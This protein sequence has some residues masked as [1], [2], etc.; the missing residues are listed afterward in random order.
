MIITILLILLGIALIVVFA[1]RKKD[2]DKA[3]L[4]IM[5]ITLAA[6]VLAISS[7]FFR[8]GTTGGYDPTLD[9]ALAEVAGN[10]I[11]QHAQGRRT[12]FIAEVQQASLFDQT[13]LE[14]MRASFERNQM[15]ILAVEPARPGFVP[16]E[17]V[18]FITEAGLGIDAIENALRNH[19]D[20]EVFV[21]LAGLPSEEAAGMARR[22]S[23]V[24]FYVIDEQPM[25][26]WTAF[27]EHGI[28]TGAIVPSL[29][30]DWSDFSGTREDIFDRRYVFVTR[31]NLDEVRAR[32]EYQY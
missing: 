2:E 28:I 32:V 8:G 5:G 12:V 15:E 25:P 18:F 24:E 14:A 30:A 11:A 23:T 9:D 20:A 10:R 26:G 7:L 1:N 17:G 22:L 16:E 27:L 19:P 6:V 21:S 13:R 31:D 4:A 29:E 3:R